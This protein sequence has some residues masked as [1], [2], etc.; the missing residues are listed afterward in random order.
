VGH[1]SRQLCADDEQLA[2]QAQDERGKVAEL[3]L[4]QLNAGKSQ[5]G[6]RLVNCAVSVGAR[7]GLGDSTAEEK[8]CRAVVAL[9][10]GDR[11]LGDRRPTTR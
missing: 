8:S 10:R 1:V 4:G 2:L 11:A 3:V 9:A 5:R 7:V 6:D